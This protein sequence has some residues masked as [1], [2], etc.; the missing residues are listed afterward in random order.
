M[1]LEEQLAANTAALEKHTAALLSYID[2]HCLDKQDASKETEDKPKKTTTK[3]SK[4]KKAAAPKPKKVEPVKEEVEEVPEE[5][6]S[7]FEEQ[8]D[9]DV[10]KVEG[11]LI[12]ADQNETQGGAPQADEE[13]AEWFE[14]TNRICA[15]LSAKTGLPEETQA[16]VAKH[17]VTNLRQ[18]TDAQLYA[19]AKEIGPLVDVEVP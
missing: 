6:T 9:Q 10:K 16:I 18:G 13:V 19:I 4:T 2:L 17:G 1:S 8:S 3:K 12:T 11:E 7:M 14:F 15:Q 5:Q